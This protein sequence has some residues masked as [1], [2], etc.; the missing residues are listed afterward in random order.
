LFEVW[1]VSP[2]HFVSVYPQRAGNR[3]PLDV[4][5]NNFRQE[6]ELVQNRGVDGRIST[7]P[8]RC[9]LGRDTEAVRCPRC[10]CAWKRKRRRELVAMV[11]GVGVADLA[12]D[13]SAVADRE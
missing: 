13:L 9:C 10:S 8:R 12:A 3:R 1:T 2:P 5:F 7:R 11:G 6:F 4:R